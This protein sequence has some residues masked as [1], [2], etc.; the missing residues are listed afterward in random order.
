MTMIRYMTVQ[1][2]VQDLL[3]QIWFQSNPEAV[4]GTSYG[5]AFQASSWALASPAGEHV[6]QCKEF[7]V[8]VYDKDL[9]ALC[10]YRFYRT[11]GQVDYTADF[12]SP[13]YILRHPVLV[14][15]RPCNFFQIFIPLSS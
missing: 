12:F 15:D 9:C 11:G 13:A 5:V 3:P 1:G 7:P 10:Q 4:A 2:L 8:K 6:L 14:K